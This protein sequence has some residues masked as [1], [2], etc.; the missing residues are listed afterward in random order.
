ME[1]TDTEKRLPD[2]GVIALQVHGG[3]D[4]TKEFVRYRNVRVKELKK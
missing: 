3:G 4:H 2:K 1:Y